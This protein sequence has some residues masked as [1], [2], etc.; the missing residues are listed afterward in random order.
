MFVC[1]SCHLSCCFWHLAGDPCSCVSEMLGACCPTAFCCVNF[2]VLQTSRGPLTI[3]Y[4]VVPWPCHLWI[5]TNS[6][7]SLDPLMNIST[8]SISTFAVFDF[9]RTPFWISFCAVAP[10]FESKMRSL[11]GWAFTIRFR[12]AAWCFVSNMGSCPGHRTWLSQVL[13]PV[14]TLFDFSVKCHRWCS[15]RAEAAGPEQACWAMGCHMVLLLTGEFLAVS[16]CHRPCDRRPVRWVPYMRPIASDCSDS[17]RSWCS[18]RFLHSYQ[19]CRQHAGIL[20]HLLWSSW[21]CKMSGRILWPCRWAHEFATSSVSCWN[22]V[23]PW[24]FASWC[25]LPL[26]RGSLFHYKTWIS[27]SQ[28]GRNIASPNSNRPLFPIA[29]RC[30]TRHKPSYFWNRWPRDRISYPVGASDHITCRTPLSVCGLQVQRQYHAGL[31]KLP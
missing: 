16:F 18:P 12:L 30:S 4:A 2:W 1:R 21:S 29:S 6:L 7:S 24:S 22:A 31:R 8:Y 15:W 13:C 20:Q 11:N 25:P 17:W 10:G 26:C 27:S 23:G 3:S 5:S 28:R 19:K 9:Q 14:A